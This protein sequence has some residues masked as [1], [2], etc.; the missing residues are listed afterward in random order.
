MAYCCYLEALQKPIEF[1]NI[2]WIFSVHKP[3]DKETL[4]I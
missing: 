1:L 3:L 4:I 2:V